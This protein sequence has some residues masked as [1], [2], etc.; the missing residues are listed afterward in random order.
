MGLNENGKPKKKKGGFQIVVT[1]ADNMEV[2]NGYSPVPNAKKQTD[3]T[4][5]DNNS[6]EKEE[7]LIMKKRKQRVDPTLG[8]IIVW[9]KVGDFSALLPS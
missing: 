6:I 8:G 4:E 3:G 7:D 9:R 2:Q 5:I 1:P